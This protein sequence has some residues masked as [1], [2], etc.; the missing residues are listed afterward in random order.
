M[1]PDDY[2]EDDDPEDCD[3]INECFEEKHEY[4]ECDTKKDTNIIS[5][6]GLA[7]GFVCIIIGL[8]LTV[9]EVSGGLINWNF[10]AGSIGS[11]LSNAT[12]GVLSM[13]IGCIIIVVTL[14]KQHPPNAY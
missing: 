3:E 5:L 12:P 6:I 13:V 10:N 8:L 14:H 1:N 2:Y 4:H 11:S 9:F 7:I